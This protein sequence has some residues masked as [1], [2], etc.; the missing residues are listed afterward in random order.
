MFLKKQQQWVFI[1]HRNTL[2]HPVLFSWSKLSSYR[3]IRIPGWSL[4]SRGSFSKNGLT[5][6]VPAQ[7]KQNL[8][9]RHCIQRLLECTHHM[10]SWKIKPHTSNGIRP[11]RI[12]LKKW[13]L[14]WSHSRWF[15]TWASALTAKGSVLSCTFFISPLLGGWFAENYRKCVCSKRP[16]FPSNWIVTP[17]TSVYFRG[18]SVISS[19][20]SI[21]A[22]CPDFCLHRMHSKMHH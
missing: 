5:R 16:P 3:S 2:F 19:S 9:P 7:H 15:G 6:G 14:K 13:L 17:L 4:V 12:L 22:V 11:L 20:I 10:R 18:I 21:S 8:L 1:Q